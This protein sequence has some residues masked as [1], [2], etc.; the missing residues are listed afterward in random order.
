ME[1]LSEWHLGFGRV[2]LNSRHR[3]RPPP[4]RSRSRNWRVERLRRRPVNGARQPGET[5]PESRCAG[6]EWRRCDLE[7]VGCVNRQMHSHPICTLL[8][9]EQSALGSASMSCRTTDAPERP[10]RRRVNDSPICGISLLFAS[11]LAV[12]PPLINNYPAHSAGRRPTVRV[13]RRPTLSGETNLLRPAAGGRFS[14]TKTCRANR[15]SAEPFRRILRN[16]HE[17]AVGCGSR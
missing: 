9:K 4:L 17:D 11:F 15:A 13:S 6:A 10:S 5:G 16:P 1:N 14:S 7:A 2:K 12:C 3:L 8:G